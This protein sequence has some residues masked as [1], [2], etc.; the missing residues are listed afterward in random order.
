MHVLKYIAKYVA[1]VER[2][3]KTCNN[4]LKRICSS[5]EASNPAIVAYRKFI[6][7]MI[8]EHDIG[9]QETCHLLLKLPLVDCS[10][11]FTSLNVGCK[12]L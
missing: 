7:K 11:S 10:H 5:Q 6:T 12:V 2:K 4:M 9:V 3:S 8:V 1:K